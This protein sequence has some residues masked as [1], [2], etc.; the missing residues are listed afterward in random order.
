VRIQDDK[1][2]IKNYIRCNWK[3]N[4]PKLILS[5]LNSKIQSKE[6][7]EVYIEGLVKVALDTG[8]IL[9]MYIIKTTFFK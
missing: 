1:E 3:L 7:K 4:E 8:N 6:N 9:N 5:I 2:S